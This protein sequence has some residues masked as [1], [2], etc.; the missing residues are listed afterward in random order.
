M[1]VNVNVDKWIKAAAVFGILRKHCNGRGL[2]C[3]VTAD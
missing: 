3:D 1:N 2:N